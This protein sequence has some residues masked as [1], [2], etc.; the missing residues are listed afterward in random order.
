[1]SPSAGSVTTEAGRRAREPI[2]WIAHRSGTSIAFASGGDWIAFY[3]LR[4]SPEQGKSKGGKIH[5]DEAIFTHS[6]A[7]IVFARSESR[8]GEESEVD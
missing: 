1:M 5:S 8:C 4:S 2:A 3:Q 6:V 7:L